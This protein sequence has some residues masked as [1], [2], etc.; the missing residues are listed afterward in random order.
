MLR[1][2][3]SASRHVRKHG[4]RLESARP[5]RCGERLG[6]SRKGRQGREGSETGRSL[7]FLCVLG[8]LC[9]RHLKHPPQLRVS[10]SPNS[11][12]VFKRAVGRLKVLLNYLRI[13]LLCLLAPLIS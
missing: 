6:A 10:R 13:R 3:K 1:E 2:T 5:I 12:R 11:V 4:G 8:D 9:V 7:V